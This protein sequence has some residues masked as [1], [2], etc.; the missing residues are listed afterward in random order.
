MSMHKL[1]QGTDF[2]ALRNVLQ[3]L[4]SSTIFL[5]SRRLR[6]DVLVHFTYLTYFQ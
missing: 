2:S 1:E 6:V 3:M 4:F 5:R